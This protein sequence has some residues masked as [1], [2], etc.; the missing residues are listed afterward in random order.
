MFSVPRGYK[1]L[2]TM[3]A[4]AIKIDDVRGVRDI[5]RDPAGDVVYVKCG[6]STWAEIQYKASQKI[7]VLHTGDI[8][9]FKESQM[10]L[11]GVENVLG[12]DGA[13]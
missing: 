2:S 5:I 4:D 9:R 13:K 11:D 3:A 10:Y 12:K 8:R 1:S 7:G 6:P